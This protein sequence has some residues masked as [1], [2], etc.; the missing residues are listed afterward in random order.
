MSFK[1]ETDYVGEV[2]NIR[3]PSH[4]KPI[5]IRVAPNTPLKMIVPLNGYARITFKEEGKRK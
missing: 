1:I 4:D 5:V 2:T 3:V